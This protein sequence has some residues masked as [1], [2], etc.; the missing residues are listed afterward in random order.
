MATLRT[1]RLDKTITTTKSTTRRQ[2]KS[3]MSTH[4]E[5]DTMTNAATTVSEED[6]GW[7]NEVGNKA[8]MLRNT[9]KLVPLNENENF[10]GTKDKDTGDSKD[11]HS[12]N[13]KE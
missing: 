11:E 5:E 13:A 4:V 8:M 3:T 10:S 9:S 7:L 12:S 6:T 1:K 2:G